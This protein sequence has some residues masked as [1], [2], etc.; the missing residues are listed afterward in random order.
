MSTITSTNPVVRAIIGGTAPH[1]ARLAAASGL[2]PLPQSDLLEL[3][4]ALRQSDD[5]EIAEAANETLTS[6]DSDDLL[7]AAKG[8]ETSAAVLEYLARFAQST[9]EIHEAVIL[10]NKTPDEAIADL[11]SSSPD[12]SLL[13]LIAMNQQ[14]LVRFPK[15]IDAILRNSDRSADADRRAR[16]TRRE[17]FEKERGA[18]QIAQELRSRG[19]SAAAEFFETADLSGGL[20]VEDAWLIA[21]HIEVS[22]AELDNSWLP[23]ERYEELKPETA[24]EHSANFKRA[25]EFERIERGEV[26]PERVSLIRRVMFM[27]AKDRMKLAMKGDREARSILIRDSN[28]VVATAVVQNPRVTDQE[29]ENIA[30]M[31]TVAAEVLRLIALNR[32]WARSYPII[33]NLVRNPRTPIPTVIS[34]LP[35][36]RSKDL[37][38]LSQNRNVSEAT[39]RQALRLSQARSGE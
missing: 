36:I 34:T 32:N 26:P 11:A 38:N 16:E 21:E 3:L 22:D 1:Q 28:R 25:L 23:A 19:N 10:N 27:N 6:Q 20:T 29:V 7:T 12:G 4:V 5:A 8:N 37:K 2:L 35:R 30:A 33:H 24:E 17:F 39:R 31:R 14:R 18:Q 9:R 13:D 15:I